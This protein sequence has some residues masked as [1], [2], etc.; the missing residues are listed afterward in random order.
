MRPLVLTELRLVKSVAKPLG[1]LGD[2]LVDFRFDFGNVVLDQDVCT[3][4][5]FAVLVVDERVIE[6]VHVPG[7]LPGRGVHED[8]GIDAHDVLVHAHHGGPPVLLDVVLQF[9]AKLAVVVS[10]GEPVV[11]V[12]RREYKTVFFGVADDFFE[13]VVAHGI[14][15]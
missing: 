2:V 14:G 9:C 8:A 6:R 10:R 15:F 13:E 7:C 4:A 1:G 5:L 12:A 3:V 11:D